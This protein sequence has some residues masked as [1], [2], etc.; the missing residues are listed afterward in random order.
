MSQYLYQS[1]FS[2][3]IHNKQEFNHEGHEEPEVEHQ[4][5]LR[6]LPALVVILGLAASLLFRLRR[7]AM[8]ELP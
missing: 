7:R 3:L 8:V 4:T 6:A 1:T 5:F 2:S